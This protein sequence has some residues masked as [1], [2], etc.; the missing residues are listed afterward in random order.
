MFIGQTPPQDPHSTMLILLV[1]VSG[2]VIFW[3][4][5]IRLVIIA[6]VL[7]VALGALALSQSLH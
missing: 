3:R 5:A 7:L 1:I 2:V 6:A 4:T